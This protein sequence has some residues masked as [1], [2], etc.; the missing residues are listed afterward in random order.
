LIGS[1]AASLR[2]I[3][4]MNWL[5]ELSVTCALAAFAFPLAWK[6]LAPAPTP[7][8]AFARAKARQ[9]VTPIDQDAEA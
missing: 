7:R 8:V 2:D 5:F 4:P 6:L 1:G 9:P 3:D